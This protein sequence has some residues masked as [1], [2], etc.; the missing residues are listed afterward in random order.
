MFALS[1]LYGSGCVKCVVLSLLRLALVCIC[2]LS[3]SCVLPLRFASCVLLQLN[4]RHQLALEMGLAPD[5]IFSAFA[6]NVF[7]TA[8][9]I[10]ICHR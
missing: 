5:L 2:L 6:S 7:M 10:S 1:C 8:L 4:V 3:A 9:I